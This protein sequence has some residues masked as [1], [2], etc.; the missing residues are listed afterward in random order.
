MF[1][2]HKVPH[3]PM[4]LGCAW[5]TL[6]TLPQHTLTPPLFVLWQQQSQEWM[7]EE[8]NVNGLCYQTMSLNCNWLSNFYTDV[9]K[10]IHTSQCLCIQICLDISILRIKHYVNTVQ[11]HVLCIHVMYVRMYDVIN[12]NGALCMVNDC[13][14]WSDEERGGVLQSS[15]RLWATCQG[16]FWTRYP[17]VTTHKT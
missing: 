8:G 3:Q 2:W 14:M 15:N 5:H 11:I 10:H 12:S 13:L 17:L 9:Y 4:H 7:K 1:A 16:W 6:Y